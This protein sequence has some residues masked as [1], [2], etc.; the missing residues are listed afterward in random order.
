MAK[1]RITSPAQSDALQAYYAQIRETT[2]LTAEE[3]HELSRRIQNGDAAA[4][5][6]LIES[7]LRLVVK[8]AKAYVSPDVS[9]L[10]L[11][12][13]GNMGLLK[14]AGRFDYR[15][16]VRFSTYAAWW[17][18]QAITRSL[19]NRRR[20]IRL[21]HRKEDALKRIQRAYNYLSQRLMRTPTVD[22]IAEEVFM[23]R[24]DV[25]EIMR[26]AVT[27]VSLDSEINEDNGTIM[28]LLEDNSYAPDGIVM[29]DI[30]REETWNSINRLKKR[31]QE[32]L[33][34]RYAL[35]GGERY[36]LKRISDEMGISPETVRQIEMRAIKKLRVEA[37]HLKQMM[38]N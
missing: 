26:I 11:I 12:Q 19:A 2:L 6:R 35:D 17:I 36:T 25:S 32:V 16:N 28:D 34:F 24:E 8:I 23:Q 3:E 15:K 20:A 22:E 38:V 29:M 10:D 30:L 31:E 9:L 5:T 4:R 37:D 33:R 13:D 21:P 7:N 14:A 1:K 27:P 18:K